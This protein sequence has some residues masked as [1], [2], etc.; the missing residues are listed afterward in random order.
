MTYARAIGPVAIPQSAEEL[1]AASLA[2]GGSSCTDLKEQILANPLYMPDAG[3]SKT[4]QAYLEECMGENFH[5]VVFFTGR[6]IF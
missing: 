6:G 2:D 5:F 4:A 1:L 3:S